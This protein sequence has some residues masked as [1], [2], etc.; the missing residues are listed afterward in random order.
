MERRALDRNAYMSR[1]IVREVALG[2]DTSVYI[3]AL[4]AS[5][6]VNGSDN[7]AETFAT[8]NLLVRSLC[9]KAGSL[10]FSENERNEALTIDHAAL[11]TIIDA[12]L[13]LNGLRPK[14]EAGEDSPV[15]N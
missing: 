1:A 4:P 5:V 13:D 15:K 10:M 2:D 3:R 11:K 9:D 12:I 14:N 7:P 6:I 8:A